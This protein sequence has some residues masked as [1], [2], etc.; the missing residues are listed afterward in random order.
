MKIWLNLPSL[1]RFVIIMSNV[2]APAAV[3][4]ETAAPAVVS[5]TAAPAVVSETTATPVDTTSATPAAQKAA[6]PAVQKAAATRPIRGGRPATNPNPNTDAN[7]KG[8]WGDSK[9]EEVITETPNA[10]K[11]PDAPKTL[12]SFLP[13][14]GQLDL[15]RKYII[16]NLESEKLGALGCIKLT[17][18]SLKKTMCKNGKNCDRPACDYVHCGRSVPYFAAVSGAM[19]GEG[20]HIIAMIAARRLTE[21]HRGKYCKDCVNCGEDVPIKPVVNQESVAKGGFSYKP[22]ATPYTPK[23]VTPV[24]KVVPVEQAV[25]VDDTSDTDEFV[26]LQQEINAR[27]EVEKITANPNA[28]ETK[29]KQTEEMNKAALEEVRKS[30]ADEHGIPSGMLNFM[31]AMQDDFVKL[32]QRVAFLEGR[33]K[34]LERRVDSLDN[35]LIRLYGEEVEEADEDYL[36]DGDIQDI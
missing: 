5:K 11:T 24:E 1:N 2:Q 20:K 6:P 22:S 25:N 14:A 8:E 27:Y 30:V 23:P 17:G 16:S 4:S 31:M 7:R 18:E 34:Y 21:D 32:R 35:E 15:I 28:S 29:R 9:V 3:V 26:S 12:E 36:T 19:K 13:T 33:N 10:P